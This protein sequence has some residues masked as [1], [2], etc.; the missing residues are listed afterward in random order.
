MSYRDWQPRNGPPWL[1]GTNSFKFEQEFGGAKD[2]VLDRARLGV[3]ARIPG[4]VTRE[5]PPLDPIGDPTPVAPTDALNQAG[6]DRLRRRAPSESDSAYATRIEA[7]WN[8]LALAGGP[9]GMLT[10]L[11]TLGYVA[12]NII[13]D[14][15]RYW[16]LSGST[17]T[18][19]TLMTCVTRGGLPGWSFDDRAN[20][21]SRF[22][23]L[24]TADAS[25]LSDPAGQA[26]LNSTVH[27]WRPAPTTFVGTYVILAGR[28]WGWPTTSHTW[29]SGTWGGNSCRFIPPDGNPAVL[30]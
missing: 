6:A 3:L 14:N 17:L 5:I 16:Y 23:I 29:G 13:Q 12:P 25:N 19:G 2:Q 4:A 10:E 27:Q 15:G 24:F 18:A 28:V 8:D 20:L 11:T 1:Q 21:W 30:I 9:L 26:I 22:A 7:A